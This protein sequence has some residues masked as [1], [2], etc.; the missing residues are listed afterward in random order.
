MYGISCGV[1]WVRASGATQLSEGDDCKSILGIVLHGAGNAKKKRDGATRRQGEWA[2]GREDFFA[3]S[4]C[5]LVTSSRLSWRS[6][7]PWR[8]NSSSPGLADLGLQVL[9]GE[10]G[11]LDD[12]RRTE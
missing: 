2:S 11:G 4:P 1:S 6:W 7:R 8:F 12:L 10:T 9:D 3:L 5:R